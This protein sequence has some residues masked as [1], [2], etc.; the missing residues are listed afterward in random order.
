MLRSFSDN[1]SPLRDLSSRTATKTRCRN[2]YRSSWWR[3][4]PPNRAETNWIPISDTLI[5]KHQRHWRELS[6]AETSSVIVLEHDQSL[7]HRNR[8]IIVSDLRSL[9]DGVQIAMK[10]KAVRFLKAYAWKRS[11]HRIFHK[12]LLRICW[13]RSDTVVA[14]KPQYSFLSC[15]IFYFKY[16][17][18]SYIF[19][20]NRARFAAHNWACRAELQ[21]ESGR[22]PD[23]IAV[24]TTV[25]RI[26]DKQCWLYTAV[27]LNSMN[28]SIRSLIRP[29]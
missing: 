8:R 5:R 20:V 15:W 24:D 11:L 3:S 29:E 27:D 26:D 23:H 18:F 1:D 17:I 25:I 19:G 14:D 4:S 22:F 12:Y 9:V 16:Y 13:T 21:P 2:C 6:R 28:H 10:C 7:R